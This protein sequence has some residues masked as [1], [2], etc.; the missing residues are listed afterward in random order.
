MSPPTLREVAQYRATV[1]GLQPLL[2]TSDMQGILRPPPQL[3]PFEVTFL[4]TELRTA[5]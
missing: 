5:I 4:Q 1:A 2:P 3:V